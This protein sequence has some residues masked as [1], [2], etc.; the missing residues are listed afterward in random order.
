VADGNKA[1]FYAEVD[2]VRRKI[3]EITHQVHQLKNNIQFFSNASAD[4]PLV[5]EVNKKIEKE[6][7][8]LAQ[9]KEKLAYMRSI[10]LD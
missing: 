9:W 2:F 4:S 7:A 5:K 3:D 10:K 8:T 1:K 6:E